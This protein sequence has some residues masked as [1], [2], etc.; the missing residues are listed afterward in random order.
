MSTSGYITIVLMHMGGLPMHVPA[1]R[2]GRHLKVLPTQHLTISPALCVCGSSQSTMKA[3]AVFACLLACASLGE[4]HTWAGPLPPRTARIASRI[5]L[6]AF[7]CAQ[8]GGR[9]GGGPVAWL[10]LPH[11]G[12]SCAAL[13][14]P[15]PL[16]SHHPHSPRS[17]QHRG[18]G[19]ERAL[20]VHP[21]GRGAG[22]LPGCH[23]PA[24]PPACSCC[25]CKPTTIARRSKHPPPRPEHGLW[26]SCL[27]A[28]CCVGSW[29]SHWQAVTARLRGD[30]WSPRCG[31]PTT[32]SACMRLGGCSSTHSFNHA[33]PSLQAANV[34]DL[35]A[36]PEVR[37][38]GWRAE[39]WTGTEGDRR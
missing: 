29:R 11:T 35:L 7:P 32:A 14:M 19:R 28:C 26:C 20:P 30:T 25:A 16:P 9:A 27:A 6:W 17:R 15:S 31:G 5:E 34:T 37:N 12:R 1:G 23:T 13:K 18:C 4:Y 24:S 2:H 21:G 22:A 33:H 39:G 38:Q 10:I 3:F 36:N 8:F